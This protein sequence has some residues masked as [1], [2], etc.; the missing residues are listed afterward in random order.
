MKIYKTTRF[1]KG[2]P[3]PTCGK[4]LDA[5]TSAEGDSSPSPGDLSVCWYCGEILVFGKG[6]KQRKP[7]TAE[8]IDMQRSTE[9]PLLERIAR[10]VKSRTLDPRKSEERDTGAQS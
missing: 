3:C 8:L 2:N 5:C 9:W 4:L 10:G 6:M 7:T 1:P